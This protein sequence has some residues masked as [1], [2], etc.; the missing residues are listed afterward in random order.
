[1]KRQL[2]SAALLMAT[3]S[4]SA[5]S[6][7]D[8]SSQAT[9]RKLRL[10]Q[11]NPSAF[12]LAKGLRKIKQ[13][14]GV[15]ASSV[16]AI[17]KLSDGV[18]EDDLR[19]QG[20]NVIRTSFG[21][22]FIAI[23]LDDVE[24]VASL[25]SFNAI[26]LERDVMQHMKYVREA[27]GVDKVQQGIGLSKAYTGKDV[28]CGIV[29]NGFDINHINFKDENGQSRV[30]YFETV[31]INNNFTSY[32]D[33]LKIT[34]YNTPELIAKYTTDNNSTYHGTHT[35]GIMAGG[36]KGA[37]K[38]ALLAGDN[39]HSA[40]IED[41]ISNPY[42][43]VATDADIIASS[44]SSLTDI[45]IAKAVEDLAMYADYVKKPVVINLSLGTNQ[46]THDGKGV[47]CQF[48]DILAEE[49]NAKI[50][51]ASGNEG[52]LKMAVHKTFVADDTTLRSFIEGDEHS[53]EGDN[54]A[55]IRYG[56]MDFYG[57]DTKPFKIQA[58]ICNTER[59]TIIK[60]FEV[61]MTE[62]ANN[63][64]WQYWCSS[65]FKQYDTDILDTSF[66]KY[67]SGYVG[68]SWTVDSVS[69]RRY[70]TIDVYVIDNPE[71]NAN[72]KYR[73]GFEIVG[74]DGQ[75]VDGY[76]AT[77]TATFDNNGIAGWDDGTADGSVS[78][79]AT[80]MGTL[81]VGSYSTTD[82]WAQLDGYAYSQ[83]GSDVV[84][85]EVTPLSSYGTLIDGRTL[86][87]VLA[88]GAFVVSSMNRYY[89]QAVGLADADTLLSA[90]ALT[91]TKDPY[92]WSAG[93]SMA[94][95]VV[96]GIIALWLEADPTLTMDQI[97]DI[98]GKTSVIDD[99]LRKADPAQIG[100]GKID[101]YEG[102]KEVLRR[103]GDNTGIRNLQSDNSRLVATAVGDRK[104]KVFVAGEKQLKVEAF[105]MSGN[106]VATVTANG[107]EATVDLSAFPK[108]SY[109]IRANGK[110]SKCIL[111]K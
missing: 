86:P 49:L 21:F 46:G 96:S 92:A 35:M 50:V 24:R 22:A 104:V 36:Y 48:F 95:P 82:S 14:V 33:Y 26:Q 109:V 78:D 74:E 11:K 84:R 10:E 68:M 3:L 39:M 105:A 44:C 51:L 28:V 93:T 90:V 79:M 47:I 71:T 88:P 34:S 5:Q 32:D 63:G 61:P 31:A 83:P 80:A 110:L 38:A 56:Q 76:A 98:I 53:V 30:K 59:N 65:N 45:Q 9:L 43:G 4:V 23:P 94:C 20:V 73:L 89:M 57:N 52:N 18:T 2:L 13:D 69:M 42:Y 41:N 40:T 62:E 85:G 12:A 27:T 7:L 106:S 67:F 64:V 17:A 19:A 108:G 87:H 103:K 100:A 25:K 91:D 111:V 99:A 102:I 58:V 77:Y 107:D 97:K 29:D 54:K 60:R 15:P 81:C 16:L 101:A 6:K 55:Y 66:D 75:R 37:T 8:L 1:M 70:A 72:H